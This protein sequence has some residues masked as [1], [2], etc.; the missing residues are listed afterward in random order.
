M[1]VSGQSFVNG[2]PG[3]GT[4]EAIYDELDYQRAVQAYI[5]GVPLVNG[6]ALQRALVAAGVSV[7]EPSLLVFDHVLTP[8]QVIMTA[9]SEVVYGMS[10]IDLGATGPVV[11]ET[12]G[13][14]PA[15][16]ARADRRRQLAANASRRLL[17][18]AAHVSTGRS[19]DQRRLHRPAAPTN[20][21][22]ASTSRARRGPPIGRHEGR[23][24]PKEEEM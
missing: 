18:G 7:S 6:V 3:P 21:V 2:Y 1:D 4:A 11:V 5:W 12:P 14:R 15:R 10:A 17:P 16:P 22:T 9:N 19:D 20:D 24:A 8:K 13:G 23:G